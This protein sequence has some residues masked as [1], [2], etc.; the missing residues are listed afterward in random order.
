MGI[1]GGRGGPTPVRNVV[2]NSRE[3]KIR[4]SDR[5]RRNQVSQYRVDVKPHHH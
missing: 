1:R 2:T 5:S 4:E 3:S